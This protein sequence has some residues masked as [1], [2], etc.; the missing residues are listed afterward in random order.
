MPY[1]LNSSWEERLAKASAQDSNDDE[2]NISD[3]SDYPSN[4]AKIPDLSGRK[5]D[6]QSA[7]TVRSVFERF[8]WE[9]SVDDRPEH[10]ERGSRVGEG[11]LEIRMISPKGIYY[12][13]VEVK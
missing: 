4:G 8:H 2:G 10:G 5:K 6:S 11:L 12:Y 1:S 7:S 3:F 9:T 13:R